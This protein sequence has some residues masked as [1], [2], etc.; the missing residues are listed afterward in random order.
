MVQR[1]T[2]VGRPVLAAAA[3]LS[4]QLAANRVLGAIPPSPAEGTRNTQVAVYEAVM[5]SWLGA[6]YSP[7]FVSEQLGSAPEATDPDV[8]DCFR[9]VTFQPAAPGAPALRSLRGVRFERKGVHL[10]DRAKWHPADGP[11]VT[12]VHQGDTRDLDRDLDRAMAHSL[13]SFSKIEFD[14]S[15]RWALVRFSSV[16][17]GLCGS[18]STLLMHETRRAWK[19]F[20]RCGGWI[21]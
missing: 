6:D 10:I 18:G 21:S 4:L 20:R 13:I 3:L 2:P 16:C 8:S 14:Q 7:V 15:G 19:V 12:H 11:L 5:R 9:G 1:T 17:G